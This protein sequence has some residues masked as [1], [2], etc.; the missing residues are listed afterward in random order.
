MLATWRA[1]QAE[2]LL[3]RLVSASALSCS[4]MPH[5]LRAQL[6]QVKVAEVSSKDCISDGRPEGV[7]A[8]ILVCCTKP[9]TGL[10]HKESQ[11]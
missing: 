9:H 4:D 1:L 8:C 6:W 7:M 5:T 10:W 11:R 3:T 2:A